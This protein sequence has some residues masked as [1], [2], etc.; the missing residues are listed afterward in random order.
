MTEQ[1]TERGVWVASMPKGCG[2]VHLHYNDG[3]NHIFRA[4][5]CFTEKAAQELM[6][7]VNRGAV[8]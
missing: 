6:D 5:G 4:A 7:Q 8:A 3:E 1:T 2:A